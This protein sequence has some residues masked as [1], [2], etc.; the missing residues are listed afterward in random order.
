MVGQRPCAR[1]HCFSRHTS[2]LRAQH[3]PSR[4]CALVGKDCRVCGTTHVCPPNPTDSRVPAC[5]AEPVA[6]GYPARMRAARAGHGLV[7]TSASP[8][9]LCPWCGATDNLCFRLHTRS[10]TDQRSHVAGIGKG[11]TR[12][13]PNPRESEM[14]AHA[15]C[16]TV[17]SFADLSWPLFSAGSLQRHDHSV[18]RGGH[19][20]SPRAI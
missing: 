15:L 5:L 16:R 8:D 18:R 1:S 2:S 10:H 6:R 7:R 12:W 4:W 11:D 19:T 9:L 3:G 17:L 13:G 14:F 20:L